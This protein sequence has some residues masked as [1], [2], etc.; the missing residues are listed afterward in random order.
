MYSFSKLL[1]EED[2]AAFKKENFFTI[3]LNCILIIRICKKNFKK[4]LDD[5]TDEMLL[6]FKESNAGI[7]MTEFEIGMESI[8]NFIDSEGFK[9]VALDIPVKSKDNVTDGKVRSS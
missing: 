1:P 3:L 7:I 4:I 8:V 6:T 2:I 5:M 9:K